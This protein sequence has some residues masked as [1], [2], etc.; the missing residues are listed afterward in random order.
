MISHEGT[1]TRRKGK[2]SI[3]LASVRAGMSLLIDLHS[4]RAGP[5]PDAVS[6]GAV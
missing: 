5:V 2:V 6:H 3:L 4:S 1:C